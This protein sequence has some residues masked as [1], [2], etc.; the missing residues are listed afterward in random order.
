MNISISFI[1]VNYNSLDY[2]K[3][4]IGS[5]LSFLKGKDLVSWEIVI[6]D[7]GSADGSIDY[8]KGIVKKHKN[9][10]LIDAGKNLG[11][12]KAC[13]I[14]A[15]KAKGKFLVFLNPD[16][17]LTGGNIEDLIEF[18]ENRIKTHRVGV[19][20]AKLV[21]SD[22]TLQYSC[23]SFPTLARQFYESYFL[24]R[25]FKNS[26][27]FGSYFLSWWDHRSVREVDWLSG[28]FM[29]IRKKDFDE[30]GG[31]DE[32]YF[33]YSEDCDLC[34]RLYREGYKNYYF[35]FFIVEH[36]DSGIASKNKALREAGVW[37]SRRLYFKKN[38]SLFHAEALSFLYFLGVI[39]R[40][41][42]FISLLIF[43]PKKQNR[44]RLA[45]YFKTLKLYFTRQ[46]GD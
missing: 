4:C 36:A 46:F 5:I 13:N 44:Q 6:I 42:L 40:I 29:F 8:L 37:K 31:F 14:G 1:I 9:I 26:P 2:T 32:D 34:L 28:A 18:Y 7:N 20:G 39:N 11:F 27:V 16:S 25:L 22:G 43:V 3:S 35:P 24:H 45:I 17:K 10:Y 19:A 15:E 41:V 21:N 33:M 38:Y 12:C 30:A 23:R